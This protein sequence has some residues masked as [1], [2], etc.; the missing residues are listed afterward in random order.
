[1]SITKPEET[2]SCIGQVVAAEI[3]AGI[4]NEAPRRK[5][6]RQNRKKPQFFYI[7]EL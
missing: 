6:P 2:F 3:L 7:L 1:M 4:Q 5:G